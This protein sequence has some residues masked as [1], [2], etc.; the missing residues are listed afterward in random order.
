MKTI[1]INRIVHRQEDKISLVFDYDQELIDLV[2]K[3]PGRKW[4][5]T[6]GYWHV[7]FRE[8]YQQKLKEVLRDFEIKF[9]ETDKQ[10]LDANN[11]PAISEE[12]K[13]VPL[14]KKKININ[15]NKT[16]GLLYMKIPFNKKDDIKKLEGAW[17][18]PGAKVW[19]AIA[20]RDNWNRLKKIFDN[21]TYELKIINDEFTVKKKRKKPQKVLPNI[22]EKKFIEEMVLRN[23]SPNT[24][25]TYQNQVNHF[26]HR[27]KDENIK[28]IST[29]KIK[30]YIFDKINNK[31]YSREYQNQVIN[32]LKR[33]YEYVHS[34]EFEDFELPRP[35]K[36]FHLPK[37]MS[38]DNVQKVLDITRNQKHKTIIGILYG[39]GLRL[40]ELLELKIEDIDFEAKTMFVNKGKGDKQR[41]VPIGENLINQIKRYKKSFLPKEYLFN[42]QKSLKYS[43]KSVQS[44]VAGKAAR[45]GIVKRITP[46][47]FRHSFAT[48]LLEDG[49]DLRV[50]QV[51]LGHRSSKTT[52]IYTYVS[53]KNLLNVKSPL[54][55][56]KL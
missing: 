21:K 26:L 52:E 7:P 2:K 45:A 19:S 51:L 48:H 47:T 30:K 4:S 22:V 10:L 40:N 46:H 14:Q 37:V 12:K 6:M 54:D 15:Y 18:H 36:G 38:R 11:I 42:G 3:L 8:D 43:G 5:K 1:T 41:M 35:K 55:N 25:E 50:I 29:D 32:A 44:I 27:F 49:V 9:I 16:E 24:I 34:R 39:C 23:K 53:R 56:L 17:W 31:G 20:N 28:E 33:Y 13:E